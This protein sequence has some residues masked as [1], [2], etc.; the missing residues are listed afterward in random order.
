MIFKKNDYSFNKKAIKYSIWEKDLYFKDQDVIIIGGGF[1]GLWTAFHLK[2]KKP[3]LK[4]TILDD[5]I[6]P[7]GASTKNAGFACFG[8]L[9]ELEYNKQ[10]MGEELSLEFVKNRYLGIEKIK[11]TF[12]KNQIRFENYGGYEL[13]FNQA[14]S[15]I[16][17]AIKSMNKFLSNVLPFKQTFILKN[18]K[19]NEFGFQKTNQLIYCPYEGQLHSGYLLEALIDRVRNMGVKYLLNMPVNSVVNSGKKVI[20]N[21]Q[22]SRIKMKASNVFVCI[23]AFT[24]I[25]FPTLDV[26]PARGQILLTEPIPNI[27]FKGTFHAEEGFYYFRNLGNRILLGGGRHKDISGETSYLPIYTDFIQNDLENFLKNI[28]LPKDFK[29]PKIKHRWGGIMGMG[30]EK[31]PI[32]EQIKPNVYCIV[33]MSGMGVALAPIVSEIAIKKFMGI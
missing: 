2:E 4:V 14:D 23:N 3:S 12:N 15:D 1:V 8:S 32:I 19:I 24:R 29:K 6:F 22:N 26:I 27:P 21:I 31:T 30:E 20:V 7:N 28:I 13:I 10:S 5:G 16:N 9:T 33:R 17:A 25:I 18:D 11:S